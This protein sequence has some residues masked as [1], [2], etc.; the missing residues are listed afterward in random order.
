VT[1]LKFE[2]N[3]LVSTA[4]DQRITLWNWSC[5]PDSQTLAASVKAR[6]C[7]TVADIQGLLIWNS[8]YNILT[9]IDTLSFN[10]QFPLWWVELSRGRTGG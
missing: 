4:V 2:D 1:G 6:Y 10:M 5:E 3:V 7:S 9:Y 8:G